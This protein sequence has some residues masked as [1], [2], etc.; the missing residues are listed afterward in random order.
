MLAYPSFD[1]P[2]IIITRFDLWTNMH[3]Y[4][5]CWFYDTMLRITRI[6]R[7]RL[8]IN[9]KGALKIRVAETKQLLSK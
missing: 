8:M 3:A 9:K 6:F 5:S 2:T 1:S 7:I 4:V